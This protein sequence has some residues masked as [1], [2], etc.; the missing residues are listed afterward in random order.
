MS[1]LFFYA[2]LVPSLAAALAAGFIA[3]GCPSQ[4]VSVPQPPKVSASLN[5]LV[6][7]SIADRVVAEQAKKFSLPSHVADYVADNLCNALAVEAQYGIPAAGVLAKAGSEHSFG[8]ND[9]II[10]KANN[11]FGIKY[12][13]QYAAE[14][15]NCVDAKTWEY[16]LRN[17]IID[18]FVKYDSSLD[19]YLHFGEFLATRQIGDKKPYAEVMQHVENSRD[20]LV[21]LA[22]SEY[23]TNPSEEQLTLGILTNFHLDDIVAAVKK[24]LPAQTENP[25]TPPVP[26]PPSETK[27][28]RVLEQS[29]FYDLELY[30]D[31][32]EQGD[33]IVAKLIPHKTLGDSTFYWNTQRGDGNT[34][35]FTLPKITEENAIYALLGSDVVYPAQTGTLTLDLVVDGENVYKTYDVPIA[36]VTAKPQYLPANTQN[37]APLNKQDRSALRREEKLL[38]PSW[39]PITKQQYFAQGYHQPVDGSCDVDE[40]GAPRYIGGKKKEPHKGVDCN[41]AVGDSIYAVLGG[42][43]VLADH[44]FFYTGNATVIDHGFGLYTYYAHQSK[45][46]VSK[47]TLVSSGTKIG[48]IGETGRTTGSHLHIGGKLYEMNMNP[49][50]F[51]IVD[52][53]SK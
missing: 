34:L 16:N 19:S 52:V 43:V 20:F 6:V 1:K 27:N 3:R 22:A 26:I 46:A 14:Y 45:Q 32:F 33:L 44:D 25:L 40:F 49:A 37:A 51:A 10:R 8:K 39:E 53:L 36:A 7:D 35:K 12:K 31:G 47:G 30:S 5:C 21:A 29:T 4:D 41:G 17:K 18:C 15:P 9:H 24:E 38:Y 28:H 48:E 2:T 13:E 11:H 50:S 42:T 23:S